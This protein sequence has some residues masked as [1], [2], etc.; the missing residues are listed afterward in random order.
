[1]AQAI[2][3][4]S[5]RQYVVTKSDLSQSEEKTQRELFWY[6]E[7]LLQ[8][9]RGNWQE[10]SYNFFYVFMLRLRQISLNLGRWHTQWPFIVTA[11][12]SDTT[13]AGNFA[14]R[15]DQRPDEFGSI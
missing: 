3:T 15:K 12:A 7:E 14:D 11:A 6:R 10:V 13:D 5:D 8:Y 4:L 1:V 9:I 2:P